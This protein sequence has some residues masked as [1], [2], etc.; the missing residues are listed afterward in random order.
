MRSRNLVATAGIVVLGAVCASAAFFE[1][2]VDEVT[3]SPWWVAAAIGGIAGVVIAILRPWSYYRDNSARAWAAFIAV[4]AIALLGGRFFVEAGLELRPLG[5][6]MAHVAII[7]GALIADGVAADVRALLR[8][9]NRAPS[10]R[11]VRR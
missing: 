2:A 3:V 1:G 9:R 8:Q 7:C 6:F 4:V 10:A 11:V 5:W